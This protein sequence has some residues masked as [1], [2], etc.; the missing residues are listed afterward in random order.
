MAYGLFMTRLVSETAVVADG[1]EPG[2]AM[3]TGLSALGWLADREQAR[4]WEALASASGLSERR[5]VAFFEVVPLEALLRPGE[6]LP[7]AAFRDVYAEA[8]AGSYAQERECWRIVSTIAQACVV[9]DSSA[10]RTPDGTYRIEAKLAFAPP[11]GETLSADAAGA[12]VRTEIVP[13]GQ[14]QRGIA[15]ADV[16]KAREAAYVAAQRHC[17]TVRAAA[18]SCAIEWIGFDTRPKSDGLFDISGEARVAS[19]GPEQG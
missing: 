11:P 18:G 10:A 13:L 2:I 17:E 16:P 4:Q 12:D 19:T 7:D 8:R 15:A 3:R 9:V 14:P 5:H 6:A 1:G